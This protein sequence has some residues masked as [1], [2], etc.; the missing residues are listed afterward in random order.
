VKGDTY[1]VGSLHVRTETD[2]VSETSCFS[3][4]YLESGRWTKS[5]NP[6]ILCVIHHHQNPIESTVLNGISRVQDIFP[7]KPGFR[8]IKVYYDSH[9]IP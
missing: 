5:E 9:G 7:L 1:S 6:V 8:L 2:P 4:N 3:S